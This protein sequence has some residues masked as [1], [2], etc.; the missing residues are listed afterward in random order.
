MAERQRCVVVGGGLL[1][2]HTACAL[3]TAGRPVTVFSRTF[4]DW[5]RVKRSEGL[6][7]DFQEGVVPPEDQLGA[8]LKDADAVYCFVGYSTPAR[9]GG[10]SLASATEWLLPS[11]SVIEA[12][13]RHGVRRVVVASS[14]GTIYGPTTELPTP[15][16]HP[17]QPISAH[18]S[19]S[20]AIESYAA[21]YSRTHQLEAVILRYSNVYGPGARARGDQGV[22]AAWCDALALHQPLPLIGNP[23]QQRDFLY[24]GDAATAAVAALDRCEPG[25]YNIGAGEG[26]R[27]GRVLEVLEDVSGRIPEVERRQGRGVDV[28]AS[29]LDSSLF[30]RCTGW[31]PSTLLRDGVEA[32]WLWTT[33]GRAVLR[34]GEARAPG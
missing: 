32:T 5:L 11:L 13:A 29:S 2:A 21:L 27:L 3:A 15:E 30:F 17:L 6:G 12:A 24:A 23:N 8:H 10:S 7:I 33:S 28:P 20:M 18:G 9:S 4:S 14:G 19:T 22:V 31:E 25:I 1:G 16:S 26:T 34:T